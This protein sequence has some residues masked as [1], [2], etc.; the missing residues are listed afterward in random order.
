MSDLSLGSAGGS[1]GVTSLPSSRGSLYLGTGGR[2]GPWPPQTWH[3]A[4]LRHDAPGGAGCCL[5][6]DPAVAGAGPCAGT[7]VALGTLGALP[8]R[9]GL[10]LAARPPQKR[11]SPTLLFRIS[12]RRAGSPGSLGVTSSPSFCSL[13]DT[14][15][16]GR[17]GNASPRPSTRSSPAARAS[18]LFVNIISPRR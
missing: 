5:G 13:N 9:P 12:C 1:L 17:A 10:P 14:T 3:H 15:A 18:L 6:A 2:G 11:R 8:A 16:Q 4:G 7:T